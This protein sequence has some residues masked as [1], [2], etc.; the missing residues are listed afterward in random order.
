MGFLGKSDI[1]C[2]ILSQLMNVEAHEVK[3]EFSFKITSN[4]KC[5]GTDNGYSLYELIFFS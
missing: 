4:E 3:R 5:P 2:K 1:A